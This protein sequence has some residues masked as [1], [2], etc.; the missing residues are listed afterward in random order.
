MSIENLIN[1]MLQKSN[2]HYEQ[3]ENVVLSEVISYHKTKD[4][5]WVVLSTGEEFP[6]DFR[7]SANTPSPGDIFWRDTEDEEEYGFIT[8]ANFTM[9]FRKVEP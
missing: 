1:S 6:C 7:E 3:R 5:D 8:A 9:I 2:L 4:R